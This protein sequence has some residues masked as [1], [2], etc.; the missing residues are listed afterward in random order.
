MVEMYVDDIYSCFSMNEQRNLP[1]LSSFG[2]CPSARL[3]PSERLILTVGQEKS[4]FCSSQ[5]NENCWTV[6]EDS[7]L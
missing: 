3:P 6:N 4:I 5:L 7:I 2:G 1:I